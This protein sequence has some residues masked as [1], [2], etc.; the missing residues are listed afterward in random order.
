M[1]KK[2]SMVYANE[3]KTKDFKKSTI[4]KKQKNVI[5]DMI[6]AKK[7]KVVCLLSQFK[8]CCIKIGSK[9]ET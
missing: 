4:I 2:K 7:K 9:F 8:Y 3:T 1:N 6:V 5:N